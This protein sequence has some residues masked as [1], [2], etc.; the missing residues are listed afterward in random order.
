M[1]TKVDNYN[2]LVDY[3]STS[4]DNQLS[5]GIENLQ[6]A[7]TQE[8]SL[9]DVQKKQ[10][11]RTSANNRFQQYNTLMNVLG[12]I[13]GPASSGNMLNGSTA[14][15]LSNLLTNRNNADSATAWDQLTNNQNAIENA[16]Q[17][18]VNSNA[19]AQNEAASL[20]EYNKRL[21]KQNNAETIN[22]SDSGGFE[23]PATSDR[24]ATDNIYKDNSLPAQL[25]Q[26]A[27]YITPE[28]AQENARKTQTANKQTGNSYWNQLINSYGG[29]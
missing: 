29:R 14:Y 26:L 1:G 22:N 13:L 23:N 27:G 12:T 5:Q 4:I 21:L 24:I 7:N 17:Q 11:Q 6:K 2:Q 15:N 3:G 9:A 8:R 19:N 18:A 20:A 10:N 16:Y 25:A 28:A